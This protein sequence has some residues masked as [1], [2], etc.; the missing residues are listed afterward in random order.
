MTK[1]LIKLFVLTSFIILS[2]AMIARAGQITLQWDAN[3]ESDLAGYKIY[4]GSSPGNYTFLVDVPLADDENQ[5]PSVVEKTIQVS[6]TA[7]TYCVVTAYDNETPS[8]ESGYSNEVM[9]DPVAGIPPAPP[10][11]CRIKN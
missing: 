9:Y 7:S 11:G 2:V 8:L 3:T 6:D 10:T 4:C 5:D 1:K